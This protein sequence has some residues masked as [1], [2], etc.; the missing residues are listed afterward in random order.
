MSSGEGDS[1]AGFYDRHPYPPPVTDLGPYEERWRDGRRRRIE[2]FRMWPTLPYR[3]DHS[4]LVAG[5][6]TSQAAKYAIQYPRAQVVGIDVSGASLEHTRSLAD[7]FG[8]DNLALHR[9]PIEKVED[10]GSSFDQIICTGVLHHLADPD[11]GLRALRGVLAPKGALQLMLYARYGRTGVYMLQEYCRLLGVNPEPR[12][13][14]DLEASLRELP[15]GHPLDHLLRDTPDFRDP[16]ALADALLHPRDRAYAVP[17]VFAFLDA[18]DLQFGRW[19]RQAPYTARCGVLRSL[20]HGRRIAALPSAEQ[21]AAAELFRGTM[22]RHSLICHRS[23]DPLANVGFDGDTWRDFVPIRTAT[24]ASIEEDLPPGI[25]AAL[26]NRAHTDPDLVLLVDEAGK[27]TFDS[28]DGERTISDIGG[29]ADFF[30][31]LW[32]QDLVVFDACAKAVGA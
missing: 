11:E 27:H 24:A 21:F 5:C 17:D 6:G 29:D 8:L 28:I 19:V 31:Q 26:L 22:T 9:L 16:D 12:E 15:R 14:A 25:A 3:D 1:V 32:W 30:E 10:L 20:P 13:I 2:H 4:I 7:R 18:A 23:G